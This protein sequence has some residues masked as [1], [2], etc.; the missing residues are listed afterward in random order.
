MMVRVLDMTV[1][2][3][4]NLQVHCPTWVRDRLRRYDGGLRDLPRCG[5]P[6]RIPLDVIDGIIAKV[7]SRKITPPELQQSIRK[8]TGVKIHI[9]YSDAPKF[10][11]C[12]THRGKLGYDHL[13]LSDLNIF[14][15]ETKFM[16]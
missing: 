12:Y 16:S 5:R 2:E 8:D 13:T 4:A 9:T 3:T 15:L 14:G 6:R 11:C 7:S 10:A 1:E